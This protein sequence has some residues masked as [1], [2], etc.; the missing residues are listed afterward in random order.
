LLCWGL[1]LGPFVVYPTIEPMIVSDFQY[2]KMDPQFRFIYASV[3]VTTGRWWWKK[4]ERQWVYRK[5]VN[6]FNE[7][8]WYFFSGENSGEKC[9]HKVS[10]LEE[11]LLDRERRFKNHEESL[12]VL[13][14]ITNPHHYGKS[15]D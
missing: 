14:E 11:E 13:T 7:L 10:V 9:P 6:G 12:H 15:N 5:P 1:L 8:A 4:K 2:E 3:L